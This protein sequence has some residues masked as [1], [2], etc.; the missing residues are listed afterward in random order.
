MIRLIP[1]SFLSFLL[2]ER[3]SIA[4]DI[5]FSETSLCYSLALLLNSLILKL[6]I[7]ILLD[8]I[9]IKL[10]SWSLSWINKSKLL[11]E[12]EKEKTKFNIEKQN[13]ISQKDDFIEQISYLQKKKD[14]LLRENENLKNQNRKNK[15]LLGNNFASN[16]QA[17]FGG[18]NNISRFNDKSFI[19]FESRINYFQI[20]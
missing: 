3:I 14:N 7:V 13:L 5:I 18:F 16:L 12:F 17:K 4:S 8:V 9:E 1:L 6:F 2:N 15:K 19:T 11:F 20:I 10:S